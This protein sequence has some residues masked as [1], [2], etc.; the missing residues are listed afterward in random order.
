LEGLEFVGRRS[1]HWAAMLAEVSIH[2]GAMQLLAIA[3]FPLVAVVRL[4]FL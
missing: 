3:A 4:R 1:V 2:H